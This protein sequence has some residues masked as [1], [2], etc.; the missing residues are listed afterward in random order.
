MPQSPPSIR[1]VATTVP[2]SKGRP[3]PGD[4]KGCI[5]PQQLWVAPTGQWSARATIAGGS[6][7]APWGGLTAAVAQCWW[8]PQAWGWRAAAA[9]QLAER[10]SRQVVQP[11]WPALSSSPQPC[12]YPPVVWATRLA[13]PVAAAAASAPAAGTAWLW[14]GVVALGTVAELWPRSSSQHHQMKPDAIV[15]VG[16]QPPSQCPSWWTRPP[17]AVTSQVTPVLQLGPGD[18]AGSSF[19]ECFEGLSPGQG[20]H[21]MMGHSPG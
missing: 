13:P 12:H 8:P 9:R 19:P 3:S 16:L 14:Q 15:E 17:W 2:F 4:L 21:I 6:R 20:P 18:I 7:E 1:L 11:W 5:H 10:C